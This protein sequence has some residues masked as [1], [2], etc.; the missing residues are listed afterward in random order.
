MY[1]YVEHLGVQLESSFEVITCFI[2]I[3]HIIALLL[4]LTFDL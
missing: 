2:R 3:Q 1:S 4:I